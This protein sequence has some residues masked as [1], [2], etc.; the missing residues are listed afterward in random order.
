MLI[1]ARN[2][3]IFTS[4][5]KKWAQ[6]T[7]VSSWLLLVSGLLAGS[8]LNPSTLGC[9]GHTRTKLQRAV[10]ISQTFLGLEH[11][12]LC[13]WVFPKK[14]KGTPKSSILIGFSLINHPFWGTPNFWKHPYLFIQTTA[15]HQSTVSSLQLPSLAMLLLH[16]ETLAFPLGGM[17][18]NP[19][20]LHHLVLLQIPGWTGRNGKQQSPGGSFME[21]ITKKKLGA[22]LMLQKSKSKH[23]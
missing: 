14:K 18:E 23:V 22:S 15:A 9:H 17:L 8:H 21:K 12:L 10:S 6:Q 7:T 5:S 13:I 1:L 11:L 2:Q 20:I 4:A 3:W 16:Q 19:P